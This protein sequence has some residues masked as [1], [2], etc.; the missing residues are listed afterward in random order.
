M[1][2]GD[3]V[4]QP[5]PWQSGMDFG[6]R[7]YRV[8][9]LPFEKQLIE[10][11][12]CSEDEYRRF[13]EEAQRRSKIRPAEYDLVPDI[14]CDP[15]GGLLTS[16]LISLAV[17]LVTSAVS[18]LLAP[19]PKQQ[20]QARR[21]ELES[22]TGGDRFLATFG[23]DSQ[24]EL[25]NYGEPI[26][27]IFGRYTGSTGGMLVAP[28]LA[29]SRMFSYGSQ[30]G[31][32]LMF[33]VGEQGYDGGQS[34]Q[35]LDV[36]AL[37][38][39]FLGNTPLDAVYSS[40]FAFYWRRN[41]T[42]SGTGR[43][44]A[45]VLRYGTRGEAASGDPETFNDIFSCPTAQ[46]DNDTGFSSV[47][48][49]SNN[50]EF[51]CYGS[52]AN[53]TSY[54]V[55]WQV[56]SIPQVNKDD[57]GKNDPKLSLSYQR[58]K[59]A[60]LDGKNVQDFNSE[61]KEFRAAV[62]QYSM[63][64]L[65]RNWSRRMGIIAVDGQTASAS[66]GNKQVA[67]SVTSRATFKI[68]SRR[69]IKTYFAD[70]VSVDDINSTLDEQ[71]IAADDALQI[72]ELFM[73][74]RTVWKVAARSIPQWRPEDNLDQVITL[75]CI[76]ITGSTRNRIG[77]VS[78]E[79]LN[80]DFLWDNIP[81][82]EY[83]MGVAFFPLQK[84][85][86]GM[87]RNTRKCEVT[88]I[89]LRSRVYQRLNGLC[90]F[91]TIPGPER[92]READED[93][94]SIAS[95]TASTFIR[96]ASVFALQV[97]PADIQ[98][99]ESELPPWQPMNQAFVVVGN[100]PVDQY[101]FI[102]IKHTT[103]RRW[104]FR[105]VPKNAAD[106][107]FFD[108]D[109]ATYWQLNA[110]TAIGTPNASLLSAS[111][112][113]AYG[114]F[115]LSAV[116]KV[117][118]RSAIRGNAELA[119]NPI[120]TPQTTQ[121]TTPSQVGINSL[122]PPEAN[123]NVTVTSTAVDGFV[124][125]PNPGYNIGVGA[126]FAFEIFGGF[127]LYPSVIEGGSAYKVYRHYI[128]NR[129]IDIG[130]TARKDPLPA[131][132]Y[133]GRVFRWQITNHVVVASSN[134]WA[135]VTRFDTLLTITASNPF[136]NPPG[137]PAFDQ[138]GEMHRVTGTNGQTIGRLQGFLEQILGPARNF[139]LGQTVSSDLA[140]STGSK[141]ITLRIS[142][143]VEALANHWT[144][145]SRWYSAPSITV[146][147][148]TGATTS[149]WVTGDRFYVYRG[150]SS[151]NPFGPANTIVGVEFI[152]NGI[153]I[154]YTVSSET[155]TADRVFESQSQYGDIS[156]YGNLVEKSHDNQPEHTIVY[157]NEIVS[158][159]D[160]PSY[161]RMTVCGLA[162]KASRNFT[163]L[164]QLRTW[165]PTGIPV[166]RFHPDDGGN[167]ALN[168]HNRLGP[169][170]LFCDLIYY[171]LT[172]QVA[173]LGKVLGISGTDPQII[174][175]D[176][177]TTTAKFLKANGL[178]FDGALTSPTNLRQ[179]VADTAPFFLCNF[180]I[181]DG[182]FSLLPALP[183]TA[184]GTISTNP[185]PIK[186]LFT[187]GNIVEDS[188]T[189]EYVQAE[190]RKP[191]QAVV[192]YREETRNQ[193][194]QERNV[195]VRW[196][197]ENEYTAVESFDLTQFCTSADHAELVGRYFLSLRKR[198]THTI[199]FKTLPY[200]IYIAPGDY[201]K[202]VTQANP[203]SAAKNGT[204]SS[205]GIIASAEQFSDGQYA[206]FYYKPTDGDPTTATMTVSSGIVTESA[207]YGT[208]FTVDEPTVSENV[209]M[210]EQITLDEE[211]LASIAA[212]EFPCDDSRVSLL[213]QDLSPQRRGLFVIDR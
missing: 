149:D 47:H 40:Q 95:G 181:S 75:E 51:G 137:F 7:I 202:V 62:R 38:G 123:T 88:E 141:T 111:Y 102:R 101:N 31:V 180:V 54:R 146:V 193:L 42:L 204:I 89:G 112:P 192:R 158:N 160:P 145:L 5:A 27:I 156:H 157:V 70:Q 4:L 97:R 57:R 119:S 24:A 210:V 15:T 155:I 29:W 164:D 59:V 179:Y 30:Q 182:K 66:E 203:Y 189:L 64:G 171:L 148:T 20:E 117:V 208:I 1:A 176:D 83:G 168:D 116:G 25:A 14:R 21:R 129:S 94:V 130:Y 99:G 201:I 50:S 105:F 69:L 76:E 196:S 98:T 183:T 58:L 197:D 170:N 32:K 147:T 43:I 124:T 172:D 68:S 35:G 138:I 167:L 107:A 190:E 84:V 165:L 81:S 126:A 162:L 37:P 120:V 61:F 74:G 135:G 44:F 71:R 46:S 9:L 154:N 194:P 142:A 140:Y 73:I 178:F 11:L 205:T 90:N 144:N 19:K 8:P 13:T 184:S 60:G 136:K 2:D 161:D 108:G 206:I 209:Y 109:T 113:T 12:G 100:Q 152:I 150:L 128:G 133:S 187:A 22:I 55:N 78:E 41:T 127:N 199:R 166:I 153:N 213:A 163:S 77:I 6:C 115:T 16:F 173:G 134:D 96:R 3:L 72:G 188:F 195:V 114:T 212:S 207:L 82:Q 86:F 39:I 211:G 200:G 85:S 104:E 56:V 53:G 10:L 26:P 87:V 139:N 67:V 143:R 36:P 122:Y 191:F 63:R 118:N 93:K 23:F 33:V 48:Q 28:K 49:P 186:Q 92:L 125:I 79:A 106:V 169:S 131:G 17:G 18:Y 34:P 45:S 103:K 177:L 65:G 174:N 80:R 121:S 52:I 185:V 132:H 91:Q 110:N 198:V 159:E 175:T 151:T